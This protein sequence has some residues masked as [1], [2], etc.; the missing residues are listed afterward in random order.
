MGYL[1]TAFVIAISVFFKTLIM[2]QWDGFK[3]RQAILPQTMK[4]KQG[5]YVPWGPVQRIE[6]A[7]N[8]TL[9]VWAVWITALLCLAVY[10]WLGGFNPL[11]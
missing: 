10:V 2:E 6:R 1:Y 11:A 4:L 7:G 8:I 3:A 9:V 5:V